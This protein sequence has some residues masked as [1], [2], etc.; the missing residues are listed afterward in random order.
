MAQDKSFANNLLWMAA[1]AAALFVFLGLAW[2]LRPGGL[3]GDEFTAQ[4]AKHR[5][6][7]QMRLDLVRESEAKK[8]SVLTEDDR[9]SVEYADQ[10]KAALASVES[11]KNQLQSLMQQG[12]SAKEKELLAGFSRDFAE[13]AR[14]DTELL[15]LA[16]KNTNVKAYGLAFGPAAQALRDLEAALGKLVEAQA[17][18]PDASRAASLAFAAQT[19]ALRIQTLLAPHI[20]ESSDAKMDALE[21]EMAAEGKKIEAAWTGLAQLSPI[22]DPASLETAKAAYARFT[23]ITGRILALSRENTNVRSLEMSLNQK[24]KIFAL[25]QDDLNALLEAIPEPQAPLGKFGR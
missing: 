5:L 6:A 20:A 19:A 2:M 1:G 18:T 16:V 8:S 25:C 10:A 3:T 14:V 13:L 21:A 22:K 15:G 24:R 11:R 12:A 4:A 23:E 17:A 9:E 7:D